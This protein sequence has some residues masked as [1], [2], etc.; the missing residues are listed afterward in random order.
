MEGR[1]YYFK[2]SL[3]GDTIGGVVVR[4]GGAYWR[5]YGT[6]LP[7]R[8]SR[9]YVQVATS[10]LSIGGAITVGVIPVIDLFIGET[11]RRSH[12][13]KPSRTTYVHT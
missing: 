3:R 9:R 8:R 5:F 10:L 2:L 1:S 7:S 6:K 4:G 12:F 13:S 11:C